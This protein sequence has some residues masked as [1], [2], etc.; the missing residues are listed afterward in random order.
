MASTSQ[1]S[2]LHDLQDERALNPLPEPG[3]GAATNLS[4]AAARQFPRG[5]AG[6]DARKL[7]RSA[8]VDPARILVVDD[9]QLI[10]WTLREPLVGLGH[11]V[12][13]AETGAQ[14][15][16]LC[17][18]GVDLVLLDDRL[19]D[20]DGIT[21]LERIKRISGDILVIL[22]SAHSTVGTA[23]AAMQLGAYHF[24][25]KPFSH[26]ELMVVID[27][28]LETTRP[29][30]ALR[31]YRQ[32][33]SAPYALDSIIGES[34][35]MLASKRMLQRV[36]RSP[37]STVLLTGESGTGKD[38]AA[39]AIHFGSS[40]A[41]QPFMNITCTA[42][43]EALLE[44]E[45]FGHERG[46]FTDALQQKKG[47]LELADGGTVFLDEI[48]ELATTLQA[49]LLR[50]LEEKSFKRVGGA[51]DLRVDVRVIAATNLDLRREVSRGKFREDLYYRLNVVPIRLPPLRERGT[52][53]A[54]L[55]SFFIDR[56]N[57]EFHKSVVGVSAP[58]MR[59]LTAY[60]WPGNIRELRNVI[61]RA[62]LLAESNVLAPEDF[63]SFSG[64]GN[65][66]AVHLPAA[67]LKLD[68][69]ERELVTQALNR[70][71]WNQTHAARLLGLNRDQVR[72]RIRKYR[73]R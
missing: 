43:P 42:L 39:H 16:A 56:L 38:L 69:V 8:S 67:G 72:Y 34:P 14:A 5:G 48:G 57:S 37:A 70:T 29:R 59:A 52:D 73:L 11:S 45:L 9:E 35:V 23:V 20:T 46:A 27:N 15:I 24:L 60:G 61:E 30:R 68:E 33:T 22:M 41:D 17:E 6:V 31:T 64:P 58:A 12:S 62:M 65:G 25:E 13:E 19:P 2:D 53:I 7:Q 36:A 49:K 40:R 21:V 1:I 54:A 10:R 55:A 50:F 3:S 28:A 44:S 63:P 51:V 71:H 26:S 32:T 4:A 66:N 47:L 18:Q